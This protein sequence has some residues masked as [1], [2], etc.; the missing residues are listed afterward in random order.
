MRKWLKLEIFS[1]KHLLINFRLATHINV[2]HYSDNSS[3]YR[4]E[5]IIIKNVWLE[6]SANDFAEQE[7]NEFVVIDFPSQ[8]K[9]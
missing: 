2:F 7:E 4:S 6:F 5:I 1:S 3:T 9:R 8:E